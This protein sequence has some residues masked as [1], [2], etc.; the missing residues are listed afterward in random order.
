MTGLR[1][2][3]DGPVDWTD[4]RR[5]L[6]AAFDAAE[7]QSR[8]SLDRARKALDARTAALAEAS[9]T[10]PDAASYLAFSVSGQ[11]YAIETR[12]T[13]EVV[14]MPPISPMPLTPDHL[15]GVYD[16]RGHVLPVFDLRVLLDAPAGPEFTGLVCGDPKPE[17]M[18]L[19]D[20]VH[21][22]EGMGPGLEPVA[23]V[24]S[25]RPWIHGAVADNIAL[26]DGQALLTDEIFVVG[27][28]RGGERETS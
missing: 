10:N 18:V 15:A 2:N 28:G 21:G 23:G 26:I 1:R 9:R 7:A 14:R 20:A 22:L 16:L 24:E 27:T 11:R 4:L 12:Y 8:P 13:C 5:R 6:A 25:G 19:V 17:F 3:T